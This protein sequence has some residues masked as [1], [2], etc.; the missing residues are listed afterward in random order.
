MHYKFFGEH[1]KIEHFPDLATQGYMIVGTRNFY[2]YIPTTKEHI[3]IRHELFYTIELDVLLSEGSEILIEGNNVKVNKIQ[4]DVSK[5]EVICLTNKTLS[6]E[7]VNYDEAYEMAE[8]MANARNEQYKQFLL[9]KEEK[10]V[11][12]RENKIKDF[13]RGFMKNW[14]NDK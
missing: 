11:E 7:E 6:L 8:E 3:N 1:V 12:K 10:R 4:V 9:S 13:L 5:N 2:N 14:G